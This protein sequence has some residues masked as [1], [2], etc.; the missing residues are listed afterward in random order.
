[1]TGPRKPRASRKLRRA[2]AALAAAQEAAKQADAVAQDRAAQFQAASQASE[3]AAAEAKVASDAESTL[4]DAVRTAAVA[5]PKGLDL[6]V[7]ATADII[8]LAHVIGES[9]EGKRLFCGGQTAAAE[10]EI[11][12]PP[13]LPLRPQPTATTPAMV[14]R[15]AEVKPPRSLTKAGDEAGEASR[16]AGDFQLEDRPLARQFTLMDRVREAQQESD[17][18]TAERQ[19]DDILRSQMEKCAPGEIDAGGSHLAS[20][21]ATPAQAGGLALQPPDQ[22]GWGPLYPAR[23]PNAAAYRTHR[24]E[25]DRPTGR[26]GRLPSLCWRADR[27]PNLSDARNG[28][29]R[30]MVLGPYHHHAGYDCRNYNARLCKQR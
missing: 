7:I 19:I 30:A 22:R 8:A 5:Q 6:L 24:P 11:A 16:E 13:A 28:S 10:P 1:M 21:P 23:P 3:H 18:I 25:A 29:S 2:A 26:Q 15:P 4:S 27:W 12:A 14:P 20:S 9:N 17:L